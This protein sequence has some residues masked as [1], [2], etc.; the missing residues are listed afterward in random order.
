MRWLFMPVVLAAVLLILFR[1]SRDLASQTFRV[2]PYLLGLSFLVE[3]AGLM[4]A[5]VVWRWILASYNVRQ[6]LRHDIRMYTYSILAVMLPGGIWAIVS[7]S[8]LYQRQGEDSIPVA[9]AGVIETLL[10]GMAGLG[11][12]AVVSTLRPELSLL[13]RPE[14][15]IAIAILTLFLLQ[16]KIFNRLIS[17]ALQK[18][19]AAQVHVHFG[20]KDIAGWIVVEMVVV[21][22]GGLAV[23]VLLASLTP[24][25]ADLLLP[26]IAAWSAASAGNQPFILCPGHPFTARWRHGPGF[27][28]PSAA[29]SIH[30][31]RG[32]LAGLEY[33]LAAAGCRPG[34]PGSRPS[35][36]GRRLAELENQPKK[37]I[38]QKGLVQKRPKSL[39]YSRWIIARHA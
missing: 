23:F 28:Q 22:V 18:R 9:A 8:M 3:C 32:D 16:P 7:R 27:D 34:F 24:V 5:I 4:L 38:N 35:L 36:P 15:G 12:Y 10:L 31:V 26:V 19:K 37:A 33:W 39:L 14:I 11:V 13:E 6:P 21:T 1:S 25:T 20:W 30:L 2:N 29:G 17:W